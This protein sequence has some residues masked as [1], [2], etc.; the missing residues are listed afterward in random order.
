MFWP[1]MVRS[2]SGRYAAAEFAEKVF[3]EDHMVLHLLAWR[4]FCR[5]KSDDALAVRRDIVARSPIDTEVRE[6][7]LGP[8]LRRWRVG[9]P[10]CTPKEISSRLNVWLSG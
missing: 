2:F 3:Q 6:A 7:F 5:H 9:E 8:E 4:R 1:I 10:G